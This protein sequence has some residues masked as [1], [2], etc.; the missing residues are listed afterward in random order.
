MLANIIKTN[1]IKKYLGCLQ[2]YSIFHMAPLL[3]FHKLRIKNNFATDKQFKISLNEH[4]SEIP[5]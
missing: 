5:V 4:K 1:A 2:S 3:T